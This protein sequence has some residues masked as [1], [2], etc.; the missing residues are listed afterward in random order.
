MGVTIATKG[1]ALHCSENP[2]YVLPEMKLRGLLP[3]SYIHVSV[4]DLY[5]PRIGSAYL[6]AAK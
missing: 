2:I 1:E 5:I 6:A 4:S 3:I